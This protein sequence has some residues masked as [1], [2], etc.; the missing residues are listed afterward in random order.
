MGLGL[1]WVL[2][3]HEA[4]QRAELFVLLV[5]GA[6][7][8]LIGGVAVLADGVLELGDRVGVDG[9][10]LAVDTEVIVATDVEIGGEGI[11]GAEGEVVLHLRFAGDDVEADALDAGGGAGEVLLDEAA[12][13]ADGFEDLG[14]AVGLERGDAHLGEDLEEA[15]A[16]GFLVILERLFEGDAGGEHALALEVFE[17]LDGEIGI[18]GTGAVADEEGE[19]H[20]LAGLA[21]LDDEGDLRAGAFA[22]EVVVDGGEGKQRGD[23]RG[24]MVDA[25]VRKDEKTVALLDGLGGT[26]AETVERFFELGFGAAGIEEG[27]KSGSEELT[28]TDIAQLLKVV[29]GDDG[30]FE[31]EGVA[32]LGGLFEDVA[33][34]ADVAGERHDELFADGVDGGIGDLG[35]E[36]LEVVEEGLGFVA[37]AG[38]RGVGAHGADGL[39]AVGGH[40]EHDHAQV[41]FGVAEG[42]LAREDGVEVGVVPAGRSGEAIEG[43]LLFVEPLAVGLAGGEPLLDF[44]V[45]DDAA[46]GEVGEEHFAGLEAAFFLD[47]FGL[48]GED[49]GFGSH[50]EEAVMGDHVAGGAEAV[51][52]E[53]GAD[54]AAI[55][56]GYGSGTV[57]RFHEGGVVLVEGLLGRV[58]GGVVIPGFGHEHGHDVGEIATAEGEKLNDVVEGAGVAALGGDDGEEAADIAESLAGESGL[59]GVH[60]VDVA[61]DGVDFPVVAHVT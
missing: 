27:G 29:V 60:P 46:G 61:A 6:G 48:D 39:F 17:G 58:H 38:E 24:V 37:E 30:L 21:G 19:V 8:V 56:K 20:D 40:G 28:P 16:D 51:A 23:G 57:P 7:V 18:D 50:D 49:A 36:L 55:G 15:L 4:A 35:E 34:G 53:S 54:E 22:D 11:G 14:A 9:V 44:R 5:D 33:L 10:E 2:E 3:V 59:A 43:D 45:G 12:V 52:V 25:T 42:A 32:V 26:A 41:F 13:E 31:L 1:G 47:V